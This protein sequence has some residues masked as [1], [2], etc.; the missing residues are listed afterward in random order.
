[1]R[2]IIKIKP[3]SRQN[4]IEKIDSLHYAVW[5]KEPPIE[6]KANLELI[7]MLSKYFKTPKSNI[8]IIRGEKSKNKVIEIKK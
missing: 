4:N 2:L 7:K 1:M 8:K 5:V 3:S 6:N